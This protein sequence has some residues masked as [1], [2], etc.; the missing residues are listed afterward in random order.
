M[1][2][3]TEAVLHH[4]TTFSI[5]APWSSYHLRVIDPRVLLTDH[6]S[7]EEELRAERRLRE[8]VEEELRAERQK[9]EGSRPEKRSRVEPP[10][11]V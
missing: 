2:P 6:S 11:D 10:R 9:G 3:R 7:I 5:G 8:R 4:G 1:V